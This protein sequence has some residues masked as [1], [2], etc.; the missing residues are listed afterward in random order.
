MCLFKKTAHSGDSVQQCSYFRNVSEV[1]VYF[2]LRLS[3]SSGQIINCQAFIFGPLPCTRRPMPGAAGN[4][5]KNANHI[6][7]ITTKQTGGSV[8]GF[9]EKVGFKI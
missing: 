6:N 5:A 8:E 3:T 7:S 1:L 2:S 9:R 4:F